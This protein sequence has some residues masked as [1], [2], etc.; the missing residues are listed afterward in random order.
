MFFKSVLKNHKRISLCA[1]NIKYTFDF[2]FQSEY[3]FSIYVFFICIFR[4]RG[5][6]FKVQEAYSRFKD[7]KDTGNSAEFFRGTWVNFMHL[8]IYCQY[9]SV[10]IM[11][12]L[13]CNNHLNIINCKYFGVLRSM[14]CLSNSR[15]GKISD[16][17]LKPK[18][19][20]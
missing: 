19:Q 5:T 18:A 1:F 20:F 17:P 2:L 12:S 4:L 7:M 6:F 16:V 13:R 10:T 3:A 15:G 11:K 8:K 14:I 9:F